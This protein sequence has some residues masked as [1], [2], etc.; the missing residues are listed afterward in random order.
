MGA[1]KEIREKG[2]IKAGLENYRKPRPPWLFALGETM[3]WLGLGGGMAG[4][5]TNIDLSYICMITGA[6][7]YFL[8]RAFPK[9]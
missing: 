6:I 9:T 7:G 4:L 8:T 2:F 1:M 5:K 3:I